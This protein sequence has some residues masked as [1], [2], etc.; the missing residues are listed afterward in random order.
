VLFGEQFR[1]LLPDAVIDMCAFTEREAEQAVVAFR[2]LARRLIVVSSQD[3]YRAYGRFHASEDGPL[4]PVPFDEDAP[5]RER[6]FPY[7]GVID[8]LDDYEKILVE[9]A[10]MDSP[11]LRPTIVRLPMVYGERDYQHRLGLELRRMDDARPAILLEETFAKWRWTRAYVENA[12]AAIVLAAAD[13]R[14][15]RC[16]YNAG[17][18][19]AL[20]Y[21]DWLREVGQAAGW[22]GRV[23]IVPDGTLPRQLRPPRADYMQ[24]LVADT[25]RIRFELGFEEPVPRDDA[26]AR[27]IAWERANRQPS[28][29][30]LIDYEAEDRLLAEMG[31]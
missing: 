24:D 1:R 8:G 17:D 2:G 23:V 12:A 28:G 9:R 26:L 20:S 4:E 27:T 13:E 6:L 22:Q 19:E 21:A 14:A 25:G 10:A 5:L 30:P 3:V 15:A 29:E 11:L 18:A 31:V 16:I 7:R